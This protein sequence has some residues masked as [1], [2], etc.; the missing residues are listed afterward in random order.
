M[1]QCDNCKIPRYS[2]ALHK[3]IGGA[4]CD[5]CAIKKLWNRVYAA[6]AKAKKR[7]LRI[8]DLEAAIRHYNEFGPTS[9]STTRLRKVMIE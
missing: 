4:Y 1:Q 6:E 2:D 5:T 7:G 9:H 3:I 8:Q